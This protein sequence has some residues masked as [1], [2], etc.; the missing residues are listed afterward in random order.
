[1]KQMS[2]STT[3][4]RKEVILQKATDLEQRADKLAANGMVGHFETQL[5]QQASALR[6]EAETPLKD[7]KDNPVTFITGSR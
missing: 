7:Q 6:R 5:R 1:M 3:N 2:D 4:T